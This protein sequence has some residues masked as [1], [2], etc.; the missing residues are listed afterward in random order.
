MIQAILFKS[1]EYVSYRFRAKGIHKLHSPFVFEFASKVLADTTD[2]P[3]YK[4]LLKIRKRTFSN[5]NVIETVDFGS[6][7]GNKDFSTYRIRVKTLTKRRSHSFKLQKLLFRISRY[8]QPDILLEMGTS[9]GLST[10]SLA[11]GS[12]EARFLTMEGC[13]SV[14]QI[15]QSNMDAIGQQ[16]VELVIG[17]FNQ[18]L[19]GALE[20]LAQLDLVF[21][22]GNHR[23]KPTL[24]YFDQCVLKAT[25]NS[26][27]IIDDI[28]WS[29]EM[30]EAWNEIKTHSKVGLTIDIFQFGIV[31]FKTDIEKQHFVLRK[32]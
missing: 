19:M 16:N 17:N 29:K 26:V 2:Y 18:T 31:F 20:Q 13:A 32:H 25:E 8:V 10:A 12:P 9:T 1:K 14:A 4:Q 23:K 22:D 11:L 15:A 6:N 21:F 5:R 27:F 3:E 28:Y 30:K 7:S 24:D